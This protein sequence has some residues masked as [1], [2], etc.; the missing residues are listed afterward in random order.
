M[1][2]LLPET[3]AKLKAE[4]EAVIAQ[5]GNAYKASK[6]LG[7]SAQ[8]VYERC[9]RYGIPVAPIQ[10]PLLD[11]EPADKAEKKAWWESLLATKSVAQIA[12]E[13]GRSLTAIRERIERAGVTIARPLG[14]P[15][16]I[17][18]QRRWLKDLIKTHGSIPKAAAAIGRTASALYERCDRCGVSRGIEG[19]PKTMA[20]KKVWLEGL[21]AKGTNEA[22]AKDLGITIRALK[23]RI[24][25]YGIQR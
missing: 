18:G 22:V 7:V 20:E 17:V 9:K 23:E 21:L 10:H 4:L 2:K 12:K 15:A 1:S 11:G 19:E 24:R 13:K 3:V 8:A 6:K 5:E 16:D 25:A 14:E